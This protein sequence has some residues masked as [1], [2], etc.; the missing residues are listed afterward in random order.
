VSDYELPMRRIE[1]RGLGPLLSEIARKHLVTPGSICSPKRTT[2][3]VR[4]RHEFWLEL[5]ARG[6]STTEAAEV[7]GHDHTSVCAVQ[8]GG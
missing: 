2:A 7:T 3:V 4:A 5:R 6:L 8:R 1:A